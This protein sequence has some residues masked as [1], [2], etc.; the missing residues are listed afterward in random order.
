VFDL[1]LSEMFEFE[2]MTGIPFSRVAKQATPK[3][4][5][6]HRLQ[7]AACQP[8]QD[9]RGLCS[10]HRDAFQY[11]GDCEGSDMSF[12]TAMVIVW[13]KRRRNDP[14]L[15]WETFVDTADGDAALMELA[16]NG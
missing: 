1:S 4:C 6:P 8:C 11:C 14:E 10:D 3:I 7:I 13:L 16:G 9:A 5:K 12:K 2:E 15:T